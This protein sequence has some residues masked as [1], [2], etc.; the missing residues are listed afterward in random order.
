MMLRARAGTL[1]GRRPRKDS[2]LRSRLRRA[3]LYPLSYGG[4]GGDDHTGGE[5]GGENGY[6]VRAAGD[7]GAGSRSGAGW[8]AD[9]L[10]R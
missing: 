3:V 10:D 2:N 5:G 7:P 9:T 8:R 6:D 1:C 4:S